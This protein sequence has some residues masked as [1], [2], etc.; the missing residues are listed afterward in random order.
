MYDSP[1]SMTLLTSTNMALAP[2]SP[3]LL[4]DVEGHPVHSTDL[5]C[6]SQTFLSACI[7]FSEKENCPH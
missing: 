1:Y 2:S 6:L 3:T 4:V 7:H 5:S